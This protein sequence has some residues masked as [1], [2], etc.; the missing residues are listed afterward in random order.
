MNG[1]APLRVAVV[2]CGIGGPAAALLLARSGHQVTV[3]ERADDPGPK[4]AGILLAPT[5]QYVLD[6]LGLLRTTI[7]HGSRIQR[8]V[9][10]RGRGKI[11][12]IRYRHL[13][14][15][16]FGLGIHRGTL[17]SILRDAMERQS[18]EILSGRSINSV[19]DGFVRD[20]EGA[21]DGPYD[22]VIVADGAR[23]A[24]RRSLFLERKCN[25]Y[26]Y[27]ALWASVTNWG[28]FPDNVLR[29]AYRGTHQMMGLLPSGNLESAEGRQISIF[30]S[31]PLDQIDTWRSRGLDRWKREAV[32]LMPGI[33][34]LMDQIESEDQITIA[35]Y[36]DV[37]TSSNVKDQCVLLGD[38][39][40]AS[41]PQLGQGASLALFDA[42]LLARCLD[43]DPNPITALLTFRE[44]R[45]RQ[46]LYYQRVSK[47][48]T[49]FFQSNQGYL[50]VPRDLMLGSLCRIPLM[51]REMVATMCGLKDGAFSRIP[52]QESILHLAAKFAFGVTNEAD[53]ETMAPTLK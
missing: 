14:A 4:G 42:M 47:W 25:A 39:S 29:Q 51:Q 22:L 7:D 30:W 9:G 31:I 18:I 48:M 24:L 38:A 43:E 32:S 20:E 34:S 45:R 28:D 49:P 44:V 19:A 1:Q 27:G 13:N 6:R 50:A 23:S 17:F 12:D 40:H 36:F 16:L 41:S 53:K 11:M 8:L 33:E 3:Y 26:S 5:G 52:Q 2:G 10:Y 15:G 37:R 46:V 35:S 21:C